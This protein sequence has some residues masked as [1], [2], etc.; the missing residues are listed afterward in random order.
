MTPLL[1]RHGVFFLGEMLLHSVQPAAWRLLNWAVALL[2]QVLAAACI[3]WI[4]RK[5]GW[6]RAL[7]PVVALPF[8]VVAL[9]Q[10]YLVRIPVVFLEEQYI[11]PEK[12]TWPVEC[13]ATGVYQI[14]FH[15][16]TRIWV[17]HNDPP[18][19]YAVLTMPGCRITDA[20]PPPGET[21]PVVQSSDGEW[22]GTIE[23]IPNTGPP[24]LSRVRLRRRD[25]QAEKTIDLSALGPATYVLMKLDT[26]TEE[27]TIW[28]EPAPI[29][30][31]FAGLIK[32][33]LPTPPQVQPLYN[34]YMPRTDGW[35]AWDGYRDNLP[36]RIEWQLP[37]GSGFHRVPLGR[38]INGVAV[39]EEGK[40]IAVSVTTGL[41]IGSAQDSVY[42]LNAA[43]GTELFRKYLVRYARTPVAFL[44]PGYFVYSDLT[45]VH[46]L[47][48]EPRP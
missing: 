18:N 5:P 23:T 35:V 31:D 41:N 27:L 39:D 9:Q 26:V 24:V 47:R 3:Y 32:Q 8:V 25:G 11:S 4:F 44:S 45:G 7:V 21:A 43:D 1:Q 20:D 36:Y 6:P 28:R 16:D 29:I 48:T 15:G 40:R 13:T 37:A 10:V 46:V 2:L 19:G 34:T 17:R 38:Q 33:Q 12:D 30:V 14:P 22:L 42:I